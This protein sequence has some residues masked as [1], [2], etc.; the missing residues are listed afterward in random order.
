MQKTDKNMP[1]VLLENRPANHPASAASLV[2]SVVG[3]HI[4]AIT[5]F[6]AE[7]LGESEPEQVSSTSLELTLKQQLVFSTPTY[8]GPAGLPAGIKKVGNQTALKSELQKRLDKAKVE[9]PRAISIWVDA[10]PGSYRRLMPVAAGFLTHSE[11]LGYELTCSQC[12][13]ACKITCATCSGVG[14]SACSPCHGSGKVRCS[15]CSGSKQVPCST[16]NGRGQW[17]EQF[18]KQSWNSHTNSYDTTYE[19]IRH[20][21]GHCSGSGKGNCYSC[22]YGGKIPCKWCAG[23]GRL[24]CKNCAASG[25]IDCSDCLASGIQH[26]WGTVE[27]EIT[28]VEVLSIL[29]EN[30]NLRRIVEDKIPRKDLPA[31]G[32]LLAVTHQVNTCHLETQ[33]RLRLDV[34]QARIFVCGNT[35]DFLGFGPEAKVFSFE[36]IAGHMLA[37]DLEALQESVHGWTVWRHHRRTDLLGVTAYFLQ[38]E[39]NMLIAERVGDLNSTPETAAANIELHYKGLVDSTYVRH[40]TTALRAALDRLYGSELFRPAAILCGL[41]ALVASLLLVVGWPAGG[42]WSAAQWS[43]GGGVLT[44]CVLEWLIRRR[45]AHHFGTNYGS[46]V[47]GLLKVNGSIKRWRVGMLLATSVAVWLA[48]VGASML[49]VKSTNL[50]LPQSTRV[51]P[52]A[53][54]TDIMP[55]IDGVWTGSY[56]CTQGP[57]GVQLG[58]KKSTPMKYLGIFRF[59]PLGNAQGPTGSFTMK[60]ILDKNGSIILKA[61]RWVVKPKGVDMID[62]S[63]DTIDIS[64]T[65]AAG[66]VLNPGCKTLEIVKS[67]IT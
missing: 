50:T 26:V 54:S 33:H 52:Y 64:G 34:Q 61:D 66:R 38:S 40:A 63:I 37:K 31:F 36:N 24:N 47:L 16:C 65:S 39:L 18:A 14:S 32:C 35:F 6:S 19:T 28:H 8:Q 56:I 21:C 53:A 4:E 5:R 49:P 55:K 42:R 2:R 11:S 29:T 9:A 51:S 10:N 58:L 67:G 1:D 57:Y 41:T 45:I 15:N 13:G 22:D 27:V 7:D 62:I 30:S 48:M 20:S 12:R 60:G 59:F 44:W 17:T 43:L 23:E 25:C 46:R 3:A